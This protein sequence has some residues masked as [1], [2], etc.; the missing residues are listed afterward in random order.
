VNA[1]KL[2]PLAEALVG[3]RRGGRQIPA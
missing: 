1:L 2:A 3:Y